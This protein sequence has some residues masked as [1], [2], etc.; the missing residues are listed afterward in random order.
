[1]GIFSKSNPKV[2]SGVSQESLQAFI[3]KFQQMFPESFR[4]EING[5]IFT[6]SDI[7][8]FVGSLT[9]FAN[10]EQD[11]QLLHFVA[12]ACLVAS[13]DFAKQD[14]SVIAQTLMDDFGVS[15]ELRKKYSKYRDVVLQVTVLGV[16]S[17]KVLEK[18]PK[19]EQVLEYIS[20]INKK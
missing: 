7:R 19:Y 6:T 9:I 11:Q 15:L 1:V 16:A 20:N 2:D 4:E 5:A 14:I 12:R 17:I 8:T 3:T 13:D 18:N 10:K